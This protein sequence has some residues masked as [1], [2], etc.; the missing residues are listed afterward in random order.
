MKTL[1][2]AAAFAM[3]FGLL[4]VNAE[5]AM[6]QKILEVLAGIRY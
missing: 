4:V 6:Q 5:P 3:F 2:F 1:I